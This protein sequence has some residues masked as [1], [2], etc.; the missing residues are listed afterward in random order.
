[1][2]KN[3]L[4]VVLEKLLKTA[5]KSRAKIVIMGGLATS[6]FAQ[7]RATYDIDGII[8]LEEE[9]IKDFLTLLK[10]AGFRFDPKQPVKFIQGLPFITFYYPRYKTYVDLFVVKTKFQHE[11]LRRAKKSKLG[12]LNL[13]IISAEDLILIKLQAGREK[14]IEDIRQIILENSPRLDFVYLGKW[15]KLLEVDIFLKD[16]LKSL[17]LKDKIIWKLLIIG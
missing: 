2:T 11:V 10:K 17:G 14:D 13:Y 12:K 4:L 1:M 7:P 16:E 8:S 5:Q 15:A 9:E 6:I 3:I